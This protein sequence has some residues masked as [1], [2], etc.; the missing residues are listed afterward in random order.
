MKYG[1]LKSASLTVA[2]VIGVASSTAAQA[3]GP[4]PSSVN[5]VNVPTVTVGNTALQ[6]IPVTPPLKE[7]L[8]ANFSLAITNNEGASP[9][10]Y[11]YIPAGKRLVIEHLAAYCQ[12]STQPMEVIVFLETIALN[13]LSVLSTKSVPFVFGHTLNTGA[14][15]VTAYVD[16]GAITVQVDRNSLNGTT[17]CTVSVLGYLTPLQ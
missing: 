4:P 2:I 15:P 1:K 16:Q 17:N 11:Y 3:P 14:G 8:H 7:P 9:F 13:Q 6:P 12:S 5:V 10:A